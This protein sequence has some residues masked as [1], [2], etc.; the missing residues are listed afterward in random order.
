MRRP[1]SS[2]QE[3]IDYFKAF[4]EELPP[5]YLK[6]IFKDVVPIVEKMI[7]DDLAFSINGRIS[8]ICAENEAR[9]KENDQLK[10]EKNKLEKEIAML[11][12]S[13]QTHK[14]ERRK[15]AEKLESLAWTL[16]NF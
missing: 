5:S 14:E 3:E 4:Y 13:R 10:E 8:D 11:Q 2:K 6:D 1:F 12:H 16:K 9:K 7:G 15:I